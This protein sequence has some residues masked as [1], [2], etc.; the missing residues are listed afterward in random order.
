MIMYTTR[1]C[2]ACLAAKQYLARRGVTYKEFDV[3]TSGS[4]RADFDK[5]GGRA[6]PLIIVKG[7]QM[8]GF[9]QA[10]LEKLL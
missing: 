5:L 9:N 3:E 7:R 1:H 6:V 10:E 8:V 2:P 4:A